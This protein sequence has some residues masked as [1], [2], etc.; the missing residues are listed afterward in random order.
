MVVEFR[1]SGLN[2]NIKD[3][4]IR[5]GKKVLKIFYGD[6]G[7][8]Y[9]DIFGDR[10]INNDGF[11]YTSFLINCDDSLFTFF[12]NLYDDIKEYL[13]FDSDRLNNH[14]RCMHANENLII[15]EKIIFYSDSTYDDNA[16]IMKI[17]KNEDSILLEFIDNPDDY[18]FGFGIR[19][20]NSGSKYK[21]FNIC[22]MKLFND[23]LINESFLNNG[24]SLVKKKSISG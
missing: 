12:E 24:N 11:N 8:L 7:D 3:I 20:S 23:I 17:S 2:Y 16:N 21:P 10:K 1:D 15:N 18:I 9:F 6:N 13:V 19:I 5:D 14:L 4:Y 22:F